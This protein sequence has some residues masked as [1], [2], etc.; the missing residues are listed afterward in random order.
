MSGD[1][2]FLPYVRRGM[3]M[4]STRRDTL[5][6]A[7][8]VATAEASVTIDGQ[9]VTRAIELQSAGE[10]TNIGVGQVVRCDPQPGSVDVE[11]NYFVVCELAAPDLPWMMTPAAPTNIGQL[12]PWM[13]LV[14]VRRQDGVTVAGR[15]T[16]DLQVLTIESPAVP[17]AELP[18]LT[19]S[20]AWVHVQSS[21]PTDGIADAVTSGDSSVFARLMCPRKLDPDT[22]Y[23][24]CLVPAFDAAVE[25]GLGGE[26]EAGADLHPAWNMAAMDERIDLPVYHSWDFSTGEGGDFE[27]LCRRLRRDVDGATMGLHAMNVGNPGMITPSAKPVIVDMEGALVTLDAVPRPWPEPHRTTFTDDM[28]P[29]MQAAIVAPVVAAKESSDYDPLVDDPVLTPPAYGAWPSAVTELPASGWVRGVNME[30]VHRAMAG[31]GAATVRANQEALVAAAWDQAG[32]LHAAT[33][34]LNRARLAAEIGESWAR[35][36]RA[37]PDADVLQLTRMLHPVLNDGSTSVRTSLRQA[38][39][40][41]GVFSSSYLRRTRPGSTLWRDW[42]RRTDSTSARLSVDH[43]DTMLRAV[44]ATD[45]AE[46][47]SALSFAAYVVPG[48]AQTSDPTLRDFSVAL[49]ARRAQRSASSI[50]PTGTTGTIVSGGGSSLQAAAVRTDLVP[51]RAVRASAIARMPAL[52]SVLAPNELPSSMSLA[53]TFDDALYW[54]LLGLGAEWI[55]PGINQL[56]ANRVRLMSVNKLFIG[57]LLIGANNEIVCELRWRD[58]PI[59]LQATCFH[60]F[61]EYVLDP[62]RDDIEDLSGWDDER[63]ILNNMPGGDETMTAIVVRGDVVRRYP[64]AHWF[65]QEAKLGSKGWEPVAGSVVEVSFLGSLDAQTA[66][67]GFDIDPEDARGDRDKGNP[68]Y[69]VGVEERV[70]AP[71]F[72]LDDAKTAHFIGSPTSWDT[73]SW[74]HLVASQAELDA[75]T[76]AR[77]TGLR[78]DGFALDDTTWGHNAAHIARATWQR[79][80]RMLIHADLLI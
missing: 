35:R 7:L 32:D 23:I 47:R 2:T 60:R 58:Y 71:R 74:G 28:T 75:L 17:A 63:S 72:G 76:H 8:K 57:A 44:R 5:S 61:F 25:R 18:D 3:A 24:A 19:D 15:S 10:V 29:L 48:G 66:V 77:A 34:I 52:E 6:G 69:F 27:T 4:V 73:A 70:G 21:L 79:P 59:D 30:P 11:P 31:L 64:S 41:A 22:A 65:M 12:R 54:D 16:T 37:L 68:G 26:P 20:W 55:V 40:P 36:A 45:E 53:P 67:Y 50:G 62:E 9:P 51:H 43:T 80:F 49:G 38:G 46:V 33:S 14:V 78:L 13:V 42:Q 39:V 1:L 56:G